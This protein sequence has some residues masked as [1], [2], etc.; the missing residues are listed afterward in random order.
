VSL[1]AERVKRD[2]RALAGDV[3]TLL[4]TQRTPQVRQMLRKVLVGKIAGE[5]F[6]EAGRRGYRLS[7]AVTFAPFLR[8]EVFERVKAS[9]Q[10][11]GG[12][13]NGIRTRD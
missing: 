1:D 3:A 6:E 4:Q 9:E 5:P 10:P 7:G 8:G 11:Y 2:V 13:P 12:G